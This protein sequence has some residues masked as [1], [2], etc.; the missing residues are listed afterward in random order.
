MTKKNIPMM[1]MVGANLRSS[2]VRYDLREGGSGREQG[3][4][5]DSVYRIDKDS[6]T[7]IHHSLMCEVL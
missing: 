1:R 7:L 6:L 3:A 4:R 5:E 2:V